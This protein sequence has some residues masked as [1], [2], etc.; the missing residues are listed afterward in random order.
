[1]LKLQYFGHL[2]QRVDSLEKT[3]MLRKFEGRRGRG[4]QRMRWLNGTIDSMDMSLS[5]L[6]VIVQDREAW[7]DA[8]HGVTE[9]WTWPSDWTTNISI[10]YYLAYIFAYYNQ[11][12]SFMK[13]ETCLFSWLLQIFCL[14][15]CSAHKQALM[16]KY[17]FEEI[18]VEEINEWRLR[19]V[20]W[21]SKV[22]QPGSTRTGVW[23]QT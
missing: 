17:L 6:W 23:I 13:V 22:T 2:M 11:N 15:Q 18:L 14:E 7:R 5:K 10:G 1:M 4:R 3:L 9:S 20:K 16:C 19:E 8:V 12:A 21:L